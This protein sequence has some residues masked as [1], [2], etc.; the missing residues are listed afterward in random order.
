MLSRLRRLLVSFYIHVAGARFYS[1]ESLPVT[2]PIRTL[3]VKT[4]HGYDI[5]FSFYKESVSF[6]QYFFRHLKKR[7]CTIYA[8]RACFD[9]NAPESVKKFNSVKIFVRDSLLFITDES[10]IVMALL[11]VY[12]D[13]LLYDM[14]SSISESEGGL[15]S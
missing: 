14:Q 9:E 13:Y 8:V 2:R 10:S 7:N 12:L 11:D 15:A 3:E 4:L 6:T 5:S 1:S